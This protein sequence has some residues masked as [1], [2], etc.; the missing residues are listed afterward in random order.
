MSRKSKRRAIFI[1]SFV[2]P[3]GATNGQAT[4]YVEDAIKEWCNNYLH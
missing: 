4:D 3:E 1:V 2:L